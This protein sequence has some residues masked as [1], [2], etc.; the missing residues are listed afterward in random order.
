MVDESLDLPVSRQCEL[1]GLPRSTYYYEPEP[2]APGF[3]KRRDCGG[4]AA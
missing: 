4:R 3:T 1:I 2:A